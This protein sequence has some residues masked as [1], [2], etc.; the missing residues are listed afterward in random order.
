[1]LVASLRK[2][3]INLKLA[4]AIELYAP[5]S[6]RFDYIRMDDMPYYNGDL[7]GQ[8]PESVQR[9]TDSIRAADGVCCVTPE[10]NRSIPALLKNAIDWGSKPSADNVWHNKVLA[11]TGASP[12]GIGTAVA[13]QHLRQIL[14]ILGCIVMPGEAY[15]S[16]K[17]PDMIQPD[18]SIADE[19]V[20]EFITAFGARFTELIERMS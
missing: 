9:F 3:S 1:M 17:T 15:I 20:R 13:Q 8:R 7:E 5:Q 14:A 16:F 10:Y 4:K 6:L 2:E 11:M 18:G 19:S 12:G